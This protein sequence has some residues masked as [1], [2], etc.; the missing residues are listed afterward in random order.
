MLFKDQVKNRCELRT[1]GFNA[2]NAVPAK[3]DQIRFARRF[4]PGHLSCL[5]F[6]SLRFSLNF[7]EKIGANKIEA[8][9]QRISQLAKQKFTQLGLLE[10]RVTLR[11]DHSTIFNIKGDADTFKK[12]L[13]N[14]IICAQRGDDIRVGFHFYNTENDLDVIVG[15]L[16]SAL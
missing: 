10:D 12:F 9:N 8:H 4:E 3:K 2:A 6:G 14:D 7:L 15:I 13:D 11:K 5:N 16:K 1:T